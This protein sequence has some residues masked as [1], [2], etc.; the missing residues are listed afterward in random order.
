MIESREYVESAPDVLFVLKVDMGSGRQEFIQFCRDDSPEDLAFNFCKEHELNVKVYDFISESLRQKYHQLQ[1]GVLTESKSK[2]ANTKTPKTAPRPKLSKEAQTAFKGLQDSDSSPRLQN[3]P[4][5]AESNPNLFASSST[6]GFLSNERHH[7]AKAADEIEESYAGSIQSPDVYSR[8]F[9]D[10]KRKQAVSP[11]HESAKYLK[12][13]SRPKSAENLRRSGE[14]VQASNRLYYCGMKNKALR[15]QEYAQ[16]GKL[17][18]A[19]DSEMMPFAPTINPI[20]QVLAASRPSS[21]NMP[22]YERLL[23]SGKATAKK[24]EL[25]RE[26]RSQIEDSKCKFKP[27][28]DRM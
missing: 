10:A 4:T 7:L 24:K 20:S 1:T 23:A 25:F 14:G 19:V 26:M 11:L 28:I 15:D 17:R 22:A 27:K 3:R 13:V 5:A 21:Q 8:L 2:A 16:I 6:R 12:T 9:T 18:E